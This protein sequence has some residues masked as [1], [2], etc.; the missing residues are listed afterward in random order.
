MNRSLDQS[1]QLLDAVVRWRKRQVMAVATGAASFT[2]ALIGGAIQS[3]LLAQLGV[4][5]FLAC[6]IAIVAIGVVT[7]RI[8][9]RVSVDESAPE[10]PNR[11]PH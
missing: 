1:Q 5:G 8:A 10:K 7:S 4:A 11:D 2:L 6:L 9:G 3:A